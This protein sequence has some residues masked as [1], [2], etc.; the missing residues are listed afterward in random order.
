MFWRLPLSP[1]SDNNVMSDAAV[2]YINTEGM[3]PELSVLFP[4]WTT[5]GNESL[6][7]TH[8]VHCR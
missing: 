4:E 1:S 3:F 6:A 8:R 5:W 7:V 2:H